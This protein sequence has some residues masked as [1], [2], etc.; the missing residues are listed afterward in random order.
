MKAYNLRN[1]FRYNYKDHHPKKGYKNWWEIELNETIPK[2]S[3]R[4]KVKK[5]LKSIIQ[6][7]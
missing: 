3:V 6:F 4:F 5:K 2:S 7:H 1:K